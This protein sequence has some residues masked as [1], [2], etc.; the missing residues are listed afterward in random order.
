MRASLV[1]AG[2]DDRSRRGRHALSARYDACVRAGE[3]KAELVI[4]NGSGD[5]EGGAWLT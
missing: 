3:V 2:I 1:E 5:A 4:R